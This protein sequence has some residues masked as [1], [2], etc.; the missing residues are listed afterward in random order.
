MNNIPVEVAKIRAKVENDLKI[1]D[2]LSKCK[3][4]FDH[5]MNEYYL[6]KKIVYEDILGYI[7]SVCESQNF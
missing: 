1:A 2:D 3:T 6:T 7:D 4:S 5:G